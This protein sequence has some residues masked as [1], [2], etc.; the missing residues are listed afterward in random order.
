MENRTC[1]KKRLKQAHERGDMA[2]SS[3]SSGALIL[4]GGIGFVLFIPNFFPDFRALFQVSL[5]SKNVEEALFICL[6]TV[7]YPLMLI[8]IFLFAVSFLS[9]FLQTGWSWSFKRFSSR[10]FQKNG[11]VNLGTTILKFIFLSCFICLFYFFQPK[12]HTL[13]LEQNKLSY[14]FSHLRVFILILLFGCLLIG[15]I[16]YLLVR[17]KRHRKLL[18]TRKEVLDEMKEDGNLKKRKGSPRKRGS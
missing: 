18:M 6:K 10:L 8:I 12:A 5:S 3:D 2:V 14:F 16:D 15:V 4:L 7:F 11:S 9:V 17:I 1:D 13:F